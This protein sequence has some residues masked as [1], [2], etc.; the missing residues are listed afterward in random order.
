M[1]SIVLY[2]CKERFLI[3]TKECVLSSIIRL[4]TSKHINF[5]VL[6]AIL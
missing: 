2:L 4:K 6:T 3:R 1:V 5:Q